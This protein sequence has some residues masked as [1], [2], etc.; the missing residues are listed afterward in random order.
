MSRL[1]LRRGLLRSTAAIPRWV[2]NGT[3]YNSVSGGAVDLPNYEVGDIFIMFGATANQSFSTSDPGWAQITNSP[4]GTGTAGIAGSH[5]LT[6]WWKRA[7]SAAETDP[8][9]VDGGDHHVG[10]IASFRGCIA[11]GDPF[12]GTSNGAAESSSTT[13]T[14][15]SI[16]TTH[17]NCLIVNA[18]A[19]DRDVDT[20]DG[21]SAWT[22]AGLMNVTER[23]DQGRTTSTGSLL[24]F[25]TGGLAAPGVTG[26]TTVTQANNGY[27]HL[28][29][30]LRSV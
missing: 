29:L 4:K 25:S 27:S 15:T 13:A 9:I 3:I 14:F 18:I 24:G 30:A 23:F 21:F 19:T 10:V 28:T 2:A 1:Y 11:S 6:V 22:N 8:T 20:G 17:P 26:Q 12:S 16:T 7:E 5:R